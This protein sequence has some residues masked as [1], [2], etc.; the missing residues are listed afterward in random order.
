MSLF[1]FV[2]HARTQDAPFCC[3]Q[4]NKQIGRSF[5][6]SL[7]ARFMYTVYAHI[8]RSF[9][10]IVGEILHLGNALA[11]SHL[12]SGKPGDDWCSGRRNR[13]SVLA[14]YQKPTG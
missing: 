6:Y 14:C 3:R 1:H 5:A 11:A 8:P 2:A 10:S 4:K 9:A 13:L 7:L 12:R